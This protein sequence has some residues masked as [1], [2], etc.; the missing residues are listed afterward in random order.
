MPPFNFPQNP[1][2]LNGLTYKVIVVDNNTFTLEWFNDDPTVMDFENVALV[3]GGTYLGAGRITQVNNIN[4]TTKVFAPYYENGAQVRLGYLDFLT[5]KTQDGEITCDIYVNED[6][7]SSLS[8]VS[9]TNGLLGSNRLLT[10][11]ENLT[12]IPMQANQSKIMHRFFVQVFC[13][14]FQLV[15]TMN[16]Y[17]MV[18][19]AISNSEIMLHAMV[20]YLSK[21]ARLTQ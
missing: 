20:I 10:K 19:Q 7:S 9:T 11:P 17:Q 6:N 14:N 1:S 13:Q 2:Q 18:H 5:S 12:L 4:I 15:L 16:D 21:N 8:E 3:P